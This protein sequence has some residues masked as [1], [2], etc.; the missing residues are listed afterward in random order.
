LVGSVASREVKEWELV[1]YVIGE[2][3][4]MK[5]AINN[6]RRICEEHLKGCYYIEVVDLRK[7]PERAAKDQIFAV[8]T[9][10]SN[11]PEPIRRIIGDLSMEEKVLVG[12]NIKPKK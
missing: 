12:L 2:T 6:L 4:R 1:L 10:I 7:H 5:D 11:L 3:P 9:V 8:P